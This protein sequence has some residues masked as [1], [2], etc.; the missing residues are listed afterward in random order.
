MDHWGSKGNS[1]YQISEYTISHCNKNQYSFGRETDQWTGH[2]TKRKL[3]SDTSGISNQWGKD[4][5]FI[6]CWHS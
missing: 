2:S 4:D 1:L 5:L 3:I 6:K